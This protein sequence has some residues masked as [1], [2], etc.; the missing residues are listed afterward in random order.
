[1]DYIGNEDYYKKGDNQ[2]R[3]TYDP[4][5]IVSTHVL[6][7]RNILTRGAGAKLRLGERVADN[8]G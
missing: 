1:M 8:R 2:R 6:S 5:E 7:N 3:K 4:V